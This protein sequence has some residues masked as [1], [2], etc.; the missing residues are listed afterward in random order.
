MD[1]QRAS[2]CY[3]RR[4]E[5]YAA[6]HVVPNSVCARPLWGEQHTCPSVLH[7]TL[8]QPQAERG[9]AVA[10]PGFLPERVSKDLLSAPYVLI[11]EMLLK[12]GPCE[13]AKKQELT[14]Q[15]DPFAA[16][17]QKVM[18]HARTRQ[19]ATLVRGLARLIVL[20]RGL[21]RK[22]KTP[23]RWKCE[24]H[25]KVFCDSAVLTGA[26]APISK[27]I[28][29]QYWLFWGVHDPDAPEANDRDT[30]E[31]GFYDTA[32]L[33]QIYKILE[34]IHAQEKLAEPDSEEGWYRGGVMERISSSMKRDAPDAVRVALE[35]HVARSSF[36]N[37]LHFVWDIVGTEAP[38]K[39][40]KYILDAA[41][42]P[43]SERPDFEE[44]YG[45][46][47]HL[48]FSTQKMREPTEMN[49]FEGVY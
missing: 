38:F 1:T 22:A 7:S 39:D 48:T 49:L 36:G 44:I 5:K 18:I 16:R 30:E 20:D 47:R 40:L 42:P 17:F 33:Y 46:P 21:A 11:N 29:G 34:V 8:V 27:G 43:L 13:T 24:R 14:F 23:K 9:F 37:P 45:L 19:H 26:C 31:D 15:G 4:L 32:P 28:P 2:S 10:V 25:A 12:L 35:A 3:V 41:R 6:G